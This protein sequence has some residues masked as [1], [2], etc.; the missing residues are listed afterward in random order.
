MAGPNH[1]IV[2][3]NG[4]RM[5]LAEQGTGP[6]VLLCHGF[7]ELWYS[8]RHQLSA[9]AAA[10]Y[11]AVAPDMRGYG[12][13]DRPADI[14][15]YTIL[16]LVGDMLGVMDA[17]GE[18]EAVIIG[19]DWGAVVAWR[20]AL[21]RPDRFR[22]V[23]G[24]SV[25][26]A[27]RGPV[28]ST[29]ALRRAA[30][31]NFN[32]MLY[33]QK[34]GVAEAELNKDPRSAL[35]RML[36][37]ISGESPGLISRPK[38]STFLQGFPEVPHLPG[39]LTEADLDTYATEFRRTGFSGGLNWYRNLDRN[40]ELMAP[41]EGLKIHQPSLFLG[42]E[43]DSVIRTRPEQMQRMTKLLP[44]LRKTVILPGCG[45]WTQQERPEEVTVELVAFLQE[46]GG[47]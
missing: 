34:P 29:E 2:E 37:G 16:H 13:T 31:E 42:G 46:L 14:E 32:Y 47:R 20:C 36:Y 28:R 8:W 24:V 22:A 40:W 38:D 17:L 7:P 35:L 41:F 19:H 25:P 21:L 11:R 26:Y 12:Q 1:R 39:W 10:G 30:G 18:A 5:H 44:D 43:K 23:V 6:L 45:H 9:L 33:F 15:H 3:T 4:I 27:G